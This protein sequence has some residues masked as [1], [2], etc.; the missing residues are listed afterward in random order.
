MET[1]SWLTLSGQPAFRS[2]QLLLLVLFTSLALQ[3]LQL[4]S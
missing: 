1:E 2:I 4:A 3:L